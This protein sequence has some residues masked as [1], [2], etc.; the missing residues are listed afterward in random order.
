VSDR[1]KRALDALDAGVTVNV[2]RDGTQAGW[3]AHWSELVQDYDFTKRQP[4][5]GELRGLT[6]EEAD[7]LESKG[8]HVDRTPLATDDAGA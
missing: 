4:H 2:D 8:A 5:V 7:F 3:F 6:D 1:L